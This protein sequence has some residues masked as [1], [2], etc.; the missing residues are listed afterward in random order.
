MLKIYKG[1]SGGIKIQFV[2]CKRKLDVHRQTLKLQEDFE[3]LE[4]CQKMVF[5]MIYYYIYLPTICSTSYNNCYFFIL[6]WTILED[7]HYLI[8]TYQ[9]N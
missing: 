1:G 2:E 6:T 7:T 8:N 9:R 4:E 3:E 5:K